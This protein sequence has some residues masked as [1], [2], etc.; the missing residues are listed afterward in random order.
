V[1]QTAQD[2][3][4]RG[5]GQDTPARACAEQR[6]HSTSLQQIAQICQETGKEQEV[7]VPGAADKAACL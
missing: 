7:Q 3:V 2:K 4:E 1:A 5:D 6:L